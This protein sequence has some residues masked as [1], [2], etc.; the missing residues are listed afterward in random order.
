[1]NVNEVIARLASQ[2]LG[3]PVHPNDHVNASQSSNDVFPSAVHLAVADLLAYSLTISLGHLA[4][5]LEAKAAEFAELVKSGRTHLMDATRSRWARSS[6]GMPPR[7]GTASG[8]FR[9]CCP[10]SASCRSRDGRRH[11]AERPARV[12][13]GW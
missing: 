12:S 3:R 4:E 9:R 1:M 7:S 6:A 13:P 8:G 10:R 5:V 11:R 2:R